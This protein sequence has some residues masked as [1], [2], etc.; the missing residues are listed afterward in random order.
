MSQADSK[1]GFFVDIEES[2]K[3]GDGDGAVSWI[4]GPVGKENP[5]ELVG[6]FLNGIVVWVDGDT[7]A[8]PHKTTEDVLLDAT[9]DEGNFQV[10][11]TGFHVE[12]VFSADL[13]DEVDF[14]GV[15]VCLIFVGIVFFSND[16]TG[17]A[18]PSLTEE[19][20][21]GSGVDARYGGNARARTP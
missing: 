16:D 18:G 11:S 21:D 10:G 19:R 17:Q 1:D 9:I 13:L 12:G 5:V 14:A 2:T 4:T 8:P 20:Y 6:D 7:G 3:I 15:K